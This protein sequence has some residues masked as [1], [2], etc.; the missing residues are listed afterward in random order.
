MNEPK[1]SK[2]ADALICILYKEYLQRRK[3]GAPKA[4][5]RCFGGS[6]YIQANLMKK[7]SVEDVDETCR[8]LSRNELL[9]CLFLDNS[10]AEILLSDKAVV[11]M[12]NRFSQGLSSV[13]SYL[14]RLRALLPW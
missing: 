6:E 12:E 7:W 4:D 9:N 14:E 5:A 8:E 10:T 1:L 13:L 11:C 3:S 2:D